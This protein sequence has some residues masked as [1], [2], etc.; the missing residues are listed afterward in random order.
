MRNSAANKRWF[1]EY[2]G[3][4]HGPYLIST[5][6]EMILTRRMPPNV[7]VWSEDLGAWKAAYTVSELRHYYAE[8]AQRERAGSKFAQPSDA[9]KSRRGES[10]QVIGRGSKK[11][12][13]P[14]LNLRHA[15]TANVIGVNPSIRRPTAAYAWERNKKGNLDR[16]R[17]FLGAL[18]IAA[19]IVFLAN[20]HSG[21]NDDATKAPDPTTALPSADM[22]REPP[23]LPAREEV[24]KKIK[25]FDP[26]K[27]Y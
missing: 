6:E 4:T 23:V 1:V 14:G 16:Y 24:R 19:C 8:A 5:L 2:K 11:S 27:I 21:G 12:D 15:K 26:D 7:N 13:A 20:R 10:E 18:L 17:K 3:T 9:L 25:K 22:L